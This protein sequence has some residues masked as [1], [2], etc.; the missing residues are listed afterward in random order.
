[1]QVKLSIDDAIL[2]KLEELAEAMGMH[3]NEYIKMIIGAHVKEHFPP[4]K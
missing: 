4:K 3:R 2:E 1:M